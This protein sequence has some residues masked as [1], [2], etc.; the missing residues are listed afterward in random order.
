[1]AKRKNN[2]NRRKPS[3]GQQRK[4]AALANVARRLTMNRPAGPVVRTSGD[5]MVVS[6][7][8]YFFYKG[9]DQSSLRVGAIGLNP[10]NDFVFPWLSALAKRYTYYRWRKLRVLYGSSCPTDQRGLITMGLFYDIDDLNAWFASPADPVRE[11]TQ[12]VG[13]SQGPVWGSTITCHPDGSHSSEI[14]VVCDVERAHMRTK[15]HLVDK[16]P[17]GNPGDNQAVAVYLG[18][19]TDP[20][21]AGQGIGCGTIWF[22]YE[23]ELRHPTAVTSN[24]DPITTARLA[25]PAK[26][27]HEISVPW[28]PPYS[29]PPPEQP[30]E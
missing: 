26:Q 14:Q 12:T 20:N 30:K 18:H 2:N 1:M 24:L 11:L 21:G 13:S 3:A 22:D 17:E 15:Y 4:V 10:A 16:F 6:N 25:A 9:S 19:V 27:P 28:D 23:I 5:T 7:K 8:E 29:K